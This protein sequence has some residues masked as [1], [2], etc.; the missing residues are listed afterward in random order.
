MGN[1]S[2][3]TLD[4]NY[5]FDG[6]N[7]SEVIKFLQK[8]AKSPNASA[9]N[10]AFTKHITD[11]LIKIKEEKMKHKASIPIKQEDGWEPIINMK[12]NDFDFKALCDLD[13]SVSIMP[14]RIYDML[15][16]PPLED[17]YLN[18]PLDD[19]AKEKLMGV[20]MMFLLWLTIPMSP[21]ISMFWMLNTMLLVLLLWEDL[22]LELLV[23]LLI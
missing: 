10:M 13:S 17:C 1:N 18:V 7:I 22:F 14:R 12:V 2:S 15:D 21:L 11:A 4:G 3:T 19:N 9:M 5:D 6:C 8:L 20:L 23:P 16:L